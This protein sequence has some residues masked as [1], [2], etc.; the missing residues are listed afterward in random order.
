MQD[1]TDKR[2]GQPLA[3]GRRDAARMLGVSERL[4]W[5]W[6]NEGKVPHCRLGRRV[7]YPIADLER[8]LSDQTAQGGKGA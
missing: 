5:T 1:R 4:L 7:L 3:V 2:S 6:T 8:W